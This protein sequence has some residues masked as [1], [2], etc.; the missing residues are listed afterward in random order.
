MS[1]GSL[2]VSIPFANFL[3]AEANRKFAEGMEAVGEFD[4][5]DVG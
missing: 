3:M 1:V 4:T 5:Y 2:T